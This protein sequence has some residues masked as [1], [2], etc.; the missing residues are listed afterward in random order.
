ME[1]GIANVSGEMRLGAFRS[2]TGRRGFAVGMHRDTERDTQIN[3]FGRQRILS[4][5]R[6]R[7]R[8]HLVGQPRCCVRATFSSR[9]VIISEHADGERR[10]DLT[11]PKVRLIETSDGYASGSV[12][13]PEG[14][15]PSAIAS[16]E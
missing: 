3:S 9:F 2:T 8:R 1:G 5:V 12:V 15:L 16:E 10:R 6:R 4:R 13:I 11:D 14:V 7:L